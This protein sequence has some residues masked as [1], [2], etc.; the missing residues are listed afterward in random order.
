[1]W[2][3]SKRV[4]E[5]NASSPPQLIFLTVDKL[6]F[7]C[8][9]VNSSGAFKFR[10]ACNAV[11]SLDAEQAAK[12]VVTHSRFLFL[13][14]WSYA[15]LFLFTVIVGFWFSTSGNHA[16]ALSLAA[17]IQG[18]PAFIVVP[19][20]APKCKVDNVIRY[21]GKVIWSEST[22]SSREEVASKVLQETASVLIHP[23][24]DGRIIRYLCLS[25]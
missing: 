24:N 7:T 2:V 10:G 17:K 5:S 23:Y 16:A 15:L 14:S 21:G 25:W 12:G 19:K 13:K 9:F 8:L 20:G 6:F 4:S 1:M 11:L 18:I 3:L 22:M